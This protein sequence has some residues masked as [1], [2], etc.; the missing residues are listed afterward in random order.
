[1]PHLKLEY[2]A[3]IKERINP[4]ELFSSCH[5][6]IAHVINANLS[7]CQ[8]RV[9]CCDLFHVGEGSQEEAFIYLEVLLMEG[10]TASKLQ[11]LGSQLLTIL[12][13]YFSGSL[14][15]L[16]VQMAVRLVELSTSLYFKKESNPHSH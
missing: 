11:E 2:S 12:E 6:T 16:K 1:M 10:R 4:E 13:N 9:T 15:E 5:R 8:S 3:N 14:R 7:R